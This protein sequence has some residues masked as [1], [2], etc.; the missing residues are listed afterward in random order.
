MYELVT[1]G[2]EGGRFRQE[3][4]TLHDA[5][6]AARVAEYAC[7]AIPVGVTNLQTGET[8]EDFD[9]FWRSEGWRGGLDGLAPHYSP[10]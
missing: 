1:I 7:D 8:R 2:P 6:K 4:P 9:V 10:L 5:M 3:F